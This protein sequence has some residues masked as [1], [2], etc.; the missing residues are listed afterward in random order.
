MQNHTLRKFLFALLFLVIAGAGIGSYVEANKAREITIIVDGKAQTVVASEKTVEKQLSAL[1]INLP[2][3]SE[4]SPSLN[5]AIREDMTIE[6]K[7][8]KKILLY[9]GGKAQEIKTTAPTIEGL[10][11]E[12]G[13]TPQ[14]QDT[15]FPDPDADLKNDM[16]VVVNQ[17]RYEEKEVEEVLPKNIKF[18]SNDTLEKG[19]MKVLE[20]GA[21]GLQ[22][23]RYHYIL[24]N[25]KTSTG[26]IVSREIITPS[27]EC[28]IEMGTGKNAQKDV[29]KDAPEEK[30]TA[31]S[32]SQAQDKKQTASNNKE[33][34]KTNQQAPP[35]E[36]KAANLTPKQNQNIPEGYNVVKTLTMKA[37]A[38][39]DSPESNGEWGPYSAMGN[40]LRYGVVAVDPSVIPLGTRLYI[41]GYGE[42]I[43]EDTGG[44]IKGNRIDLFMDRASAQKFGVQNVVVHILGN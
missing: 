27:K 19:E 12:L 16:I 9:M 30:K 17:V 35:K 28:I 23:V 33:S 29:E 7:L 22:K 10:L 2:E 8:A 5:T 1:G 43:A 41:E 32:E 37:T 44:A 13:Y 36:E 20:A 3:G 24:Q 25:G 42:A 15:I 4:L 31:S 14:D 40:R 39:D 38:Y 6:V 26:W 11:K 34:Q 21:D 18:I